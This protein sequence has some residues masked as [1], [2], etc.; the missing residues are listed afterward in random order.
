SHVKPGIVEFQNGNAS[1]GI[2]TTLTSRTAVDISFTNDGTTAVRPTL[3]STLAPAGLG[4][5]T[6][7]S[8]LGGV[9]GCGPGAVFPGDFRDFPQFSLDGWSAG[10]NVLAGASFSF[11]IISGDT[12]LYQLS[13]SVALEIDPLTGQT[14]AVDNL[15]AA[16]AVLAGF[17][18]TSP[19]GSGHQFGFAWD[20]TPLV[21]NFAPGTL[22]QPGESSTLT[23]ETVVQTYSHAACFDLLTAACLTA[24][25]SFGDPIG[26]GGSPDPS[27]SRSTALG[28]AASGLTFGNLAF[29][30]PT[31]NDG[32]LSLEL[33]SS[34]AVAEPA[35]WAMMVGGLG[36]IGAA[37]RRRRLATPRIFA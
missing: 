12:V 17:R 25:S 6:G 30:S 10:S 18:I 23:Y 33:A 15:D 19:D 26:R 21:V 31:F 29:T 20:A 28:G 11:R 37:S 3:H 27:V 32:I 22:L 8:C 35:T 1:S 2:D 7:Q 14:A 36:L 9:S 4:F 34:S 16:R 5:Y 24:Y 13:G